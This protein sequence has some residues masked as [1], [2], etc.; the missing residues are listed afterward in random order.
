MSLA[1][2]DWQALAEHRGRRNAALDREV[3]FLRAERRRLER[4]LALALRVA[5][6][7]GR[8]AD[9]IELL[10]VMAEYA[11]EDLVRP[12]FACEEAALAAMSPAEGRRAA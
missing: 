10:N 3:R 9:P 11:G 6:A 2:V 8:E 12:A 4:L 1:P 7:D 5:S